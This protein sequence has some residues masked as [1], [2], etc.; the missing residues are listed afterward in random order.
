[1]NNDFTINKKA[2]FDY[3]ILDKKEAGL[4]LFGQEVKSIRQGNAN[5]SGAYIIIRSNE[6]YLINSYVPPYQPKNT[7]SDYQPDRK[8]KL[9]LKRKEIISL[10]QEVQQ[11]H[12]TLVPL[13]LYNTKG[14]IKLEFA[15]ARGKKKFDKRDSIRKRDI[16]RQIDKRRKERY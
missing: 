14:L 7:P 16:K 11:K 5:I 3:E 1:M 4:C 2:Y 10:H 15:L 9:L 8:R 13:R 6:V 12:L